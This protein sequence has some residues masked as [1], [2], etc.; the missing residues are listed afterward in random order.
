MTALEQALIR[1]LLESRFGHDA[2]SVVEDDPAWKWAQNF[3]R[4]N[5]M[6]AMLPLVITANKYK[7]DRERL[8]RQNAALEAEVRRLREFIANRGAAPTE[9]LTAVA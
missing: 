4:R 5:M 3:A 6:P 1:A 2:D 7:G 9:V 8:E